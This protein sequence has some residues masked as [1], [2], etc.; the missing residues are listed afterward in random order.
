MLST[1]QESDR[2]LAP[3]SSIVSSGVPEIYHP[4]SAT[5]QLVEPSACPIGVFPG[6]RH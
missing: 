6:I 2:L 4:P 3:D 1:G 5:A